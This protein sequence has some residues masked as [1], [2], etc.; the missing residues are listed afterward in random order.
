MNRVWWMRRGRRRGGGKVGE[1]VKREG[2]EEG[3]VAERVGTGEEGSETEA[4]EHEDQGQGQGQAGVSSDESVIP[5]GHSKRARCGL[6]SLC[7]MCV[8]VCVRDPVFSLE[9]VVEED[10][11]RVGL[12]P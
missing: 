1:G 3:E 8:C 9:R 4:M 5:Q 10:E 2:S 11:T 7:V 12:H 6:E